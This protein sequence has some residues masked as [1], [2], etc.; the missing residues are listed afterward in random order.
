[1]PTQFK[2]VCLIFQLSLDFVITLF[3]KHFFLKCGVFLVK[4]LRVKIESYKSSKFIRSLFLLK[5]FN[6]QEGT[7]GKLSFVQVGTGKFLIL[8]D[9]FFFPASYQVLLSLFLC[10]PGTF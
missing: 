1:M 7:E 3:K 5:G 10:G 6:P 9:F 8:Y 2:R 4:S